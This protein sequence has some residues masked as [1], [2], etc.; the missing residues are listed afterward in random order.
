MTKEVI[1]DRSTERTG[2][3]IERETMRDSGRETLIVRCG[4][5]QDPDSIIAQ[6]NAWLIPEERAAVAVALGLHVS[7]KFP[8]TN[9]S[10]KASS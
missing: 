8:S 7:R 6:C 3:C 1:I 10:I 2:V 9:F 4:W 5:Y